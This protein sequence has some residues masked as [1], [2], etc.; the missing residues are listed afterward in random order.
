MGAA[1]LIGATALPAHAGLRDSIQDIE[2]KHGGRLGV[3]ALDTGSGRMLGHRADERFFMCSSFKGLLAACVLANVDA[4]HE[5]LSAPV[6]YGAADLLPYAPVTRA[7]LSQGAMTVQELC[8]AIMIYSD[9]TAA[10]LLLR[11]VGGPAKLTAF[12]R[13]IGDPVTRCDRYEPDNNTRSG[14]LDTTT[15]RAIV[16]TAGK[17]GLG[18]VLASASRMQFMDWM[19]ADVMGLK[20][21]R[22]VLPAGWVVGDRTGT[23]DGL[24]NDYA[25]ALRPGRAPLVM[26]AYYDAPGMDTAPQEDVLRDVG[27]VIGDWAA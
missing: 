22:A 5:K 2:K 9:N 15:P 1:A 24:C 12:I 25:I 17:I 14:V 20:R 3:F 26:A 10:D 6:A 13:G 27:R 8:A 4:G 21:L 18:D 19:Q 16:A 7:Q 23:G 11:R